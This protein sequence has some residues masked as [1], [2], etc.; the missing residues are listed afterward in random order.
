MLLELFYHS[1]RN[2]AIFFDNTEI[3]LCIVKKTMIIIIK[4]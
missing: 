4:C 1:E 3:Q 2:K